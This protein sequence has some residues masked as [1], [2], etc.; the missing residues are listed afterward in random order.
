MD[1]P[2]T[3]G[4][5]RKKEKKDNTGNNYI[6]TND[7]E[8]VNGSVPNPSE[9]PLKAA[10]YDVIDTDVYAAFPKYCLSAKFYI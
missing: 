3:K 4:S 2:H 9:L 8:I 1:K 10:L 6:S 7:D 5:N